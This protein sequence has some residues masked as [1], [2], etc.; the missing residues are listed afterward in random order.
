MKILFI[1]ALVQKYSLHGNV[2]RTW[3]CLY[4]QWSFFFI[5]FWHSIVYTR[6]SIWNYQFWLFSSWKDYLRFQSIEYQL[7]K[8]EYHPRYWHKNGTR[9]CITRSTQIN[10]ILRN[11]FEEV[12]RNS[13]Q[14]IRINVSTIG[15]NQKPIEIDWWCAN[16]C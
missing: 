3:M 11:V 4:E 13:L 1:Y 2:R 14:S 16:C 8:W 15:N 12:K 10:K 6:I 5:Y 7:N 9:E